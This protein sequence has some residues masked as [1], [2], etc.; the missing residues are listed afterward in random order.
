MRVKENAWITY[1]TK[2]VIRRS[3]PHRFIKFVSLS[4][5]LSRESYDGNRKGVGEDQAS[6]KFQLTH[7]WVRV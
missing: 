2:I 3:L 7:F 4:K 5:S 6:Y 1:T